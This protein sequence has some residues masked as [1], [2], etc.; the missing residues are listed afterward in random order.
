ML[1]LTNCARSFADSIP[2]RHIPKSFTLVAT[3][4]VLIHQEGSLVEG[5]ATAGRANGTGYDFSGVFAAVANLIKGADLA[6]CHLETPVAKVEGPFSGYP[7][8]NVQPQIIHALAD[9]GYDTCSTASNH[10]LDAGFDGLGRTLDTLD[11]NG[12]GHTGTFRTIEESRTPR[13]ID[14]HGVRVGHL[15]WTYGLNGIPLPAGRPWSVNVFDAE[16]PAVTGLLADA[17]RARQAGADV[18]VASV[19]CCEEYDHDPTPAQVRLVTALLASPDIDLVLGHHAHVV[20]PIE[21]INGNGR[22]TAWATMSPSSMPGIPKTRCSPGLPSP[23]VVTAATPSPRPK[24]SQP[25][26]T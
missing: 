2:V 3:G 7:S 13:I 11:A 20:Q 1:A 25:A 14:V 4:D 22:L 10:S 15:S 19:H 8:F 17:A 21:R 23:R 18:V 26:S 9:A 6:I 24:R 12:I 16:G 5:A